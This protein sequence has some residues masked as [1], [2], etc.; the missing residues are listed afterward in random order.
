MPGIEWVPDK[1]LLDRLMEEK[2]GLTDLYLLRKGPLLFSFYEPGIFIPTGLE[3]Y[4]KGYG[5]TGPRG[6]PQFLQ[7]L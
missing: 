7:S 6:Q 1:F 5:V 2:L 4:W 3:N